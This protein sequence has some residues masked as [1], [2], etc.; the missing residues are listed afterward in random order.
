RKSLR[1]NI[2]TVKQIPVKTKDQFQNVFF[3]GGNNFKVEETF[4]EDEGLAFGVNRDCFVPLWWPHAGA[5]VSF[6]VELALH[7]EVAFLFQ[8]QIAVRA[9]K[10]LR[11]PVASKLPNGPY[12]CMGV[13]NWACTILTPGSSISRGT[14][15]AILDTAFSSVGQMELTVLMEEGVLRPL[16]QSSP[17]G[18]LHPLCSWPQRRTGCGVRAVTESEDKRTGVRTVKPSITFLSKIHANSKQLDLLARS[19]KAS[20]L[21]KEPSSYGEGMLCIAPCPPSLV[22]SDKS[23]GAALFFLRKGTGLTRNAILDRP[24]SASCLLGSSVHGG[25]AGVGCWASPF[26]GADEMPV[27]VV[28]VVVYSGLDRTN[29][30]RI[31][32]VLAIDAGAHAFSL[33]LCVGI[34][35]VIIC[36]QVITATR[37]PLWRSS[38]LCA[39]PDFCILA[40]QAVETGK[41]LLQIQLSNLKLHRTRTEPQQ[42]STSAAV[43][44]ELTWPLL[45]LAREGEGGDELVKGFLRVEHEPC[46]SARPRSESLLGFFLAWKNLRP[47]GLLKCQPPPLATPGHIGGDS[48]HMALRQCLPPTTCSGSVP[49]QT[50]MSLPR[51]DIHRID[52]FPGSYSKILLGSER[53]LRVST[54]L[55]GG[56][57][58]F[59]NNKRRTYR[60][61]KVN[62]ICVQVSC[63]YLPFYQKE[64]CL[65]RCG[66]IGGGTW[67]GKGDETLKASEPLS[68]ALLDRD[69]LR[70]DLLGE[71]SYLDCSLTL[72][73]G[74]QSLAIRHSPPYVNT[75]RQDTSNSCYIPAPH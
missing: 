37:F 19:F 1:K 58:S 73:K 60:Y 40:K 68:E 66:G 25:E 5:G 74:Q 34:A 15:G 53:N 44:C 16:P 71:D 38:F 24:D 35:I 23:L 8:V 65:I 52:D 7:K 27:V 54:F 33:G 6:A 41:S 26:A 75:G 62:G 43:L 18:V 67:G 11:V 57:Q 13:L 9:H 17:E 10:A 48:G 61:A 28:M 4:S 31:H 36:Q 69:G 59:L 47:E 55:S 39:T 49:A 30:L 2:L 50:M 51:I 20:P 32:Q 72:E 64:R 21:D 22:A 42:Y 70:V 3:W 29:H 46:V 14:L 12:N 45:P 56:S 63:K